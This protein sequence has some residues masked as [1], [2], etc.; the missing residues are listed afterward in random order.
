MYLQEK[1]NKHY[2]ETSIYE[3][4][5]IWS[6]PSHKK[7]QIEEICN[8]KKYF[9]Q[10]KKDGNWYEYSKSKTGVSYLFSRG[11]S[12]K[13]GLPV[14]SIQNVPHIEKTFSVLPNDTV[15]IGEIY[16]P[17]QT[18]NE[19]RSIMGCLPKKAIERQKVKGFIHFYLHDILRFNGEDLSS[20]GAY[21]RYLK[22]IDVINEYKLIEAECI[23]L[24]PIITEDIYEFLINTLAEG[25]EGSI[26]KLRTA[27]YAEG[28]RPAWSMIK[29]KKQDD[30]DLVCMGFEDPT[31]I[32]TGTELENWEYWEQYEHGDLIKGK[33]YT[34]LHDEELRPNGLLLTPVTKPFFYG[35]KTSIRI[36]LYDD[37]GVLKQVG[38]V[39]SGLTDELRAKFAED[40]DQYIGKVL[41][42]NCM[43]VTKDSLRHPIYQTF[44][45]DKNAESCTFKI[46]FG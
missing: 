30:V 7:N 4:M 46:V 38:T 19:V 17:N 9:A 5:E 11:L 8:N 44:R 22:L 34:S 33:L 39:S 10:V 32:Y 31:K 23:E 25:E 35:W 1:V 28:K 12:T 13:T 21:D 37:D 20:L 15:I 18:S 16:Y 29:W 42:C 43:E 27:P 3:A 45:D 41:T 40:P 6:L 26:L 2:P 36:G 14:E 24:A